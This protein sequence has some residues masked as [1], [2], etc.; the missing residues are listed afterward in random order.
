MNVDRRV[1]L[2]H[3]GMQCFIVVLFTQQSVSVYDDQ[4]DQLFRE[5]KK[6][7]KSERKKTLLTI[8]TF[9]IVYFQGSKTM[10]NNFCL[11]LFSFTWNGF[12][13]NS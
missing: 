1:K 8:Q 11:S 10:E 13:G 9:V 6:D 5:K 12:N 7:R 2:G 4:H 3:F